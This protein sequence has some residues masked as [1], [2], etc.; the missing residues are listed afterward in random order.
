[1]TLGAKR[2]LERAMRLDRRLQQLRAA[3]SLDDLRHA[4]GRC[5]ELI[6]DRV[7]SL[8]LDLDHPYRVIFRPTLPSSN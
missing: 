6:A 7:G 5:H 2:R 1:M 3:E 8:S 4:P